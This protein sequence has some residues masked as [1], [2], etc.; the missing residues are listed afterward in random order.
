MTGTNN[1]TL[2]EFAC[3]CKCTTNYTK[4]DLL[5]AL[6]DVRDRLKLPIG[7]VSGYRCA[8]HNEAV[9]GSAGSSHIFG[10]AADLAVYDNEYGFKIMKAIM[11]SGKFKRIGY[12]KM[13]KVLCLHVDIDENKVSPRLWGY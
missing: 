12:G 6:Q 5:H 9:G 1:F 3:Q 7:I 4:I 11:D 2:Q 10:V 8:T 13:G